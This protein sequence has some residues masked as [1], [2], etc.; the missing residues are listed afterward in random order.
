V[1]FTEESLLRS[2]ASIGANIQSVDKLQGRKRLGLAV[3]AFTRSSRPGALEGFRR[4]VP[5]AAGRAREGKRQKWP[6][7]REWLAKKVGLDST[8]VIHLAERQA[9]PVK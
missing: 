3:K 9:G 1:E 7:F 2:A 5:I 6:K 8:I 4:N